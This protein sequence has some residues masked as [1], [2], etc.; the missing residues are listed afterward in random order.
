[1]FGRQ[2]A[3]SINHY[4]KLGLWVTTFRPRNDILGRG[5]NFVQDVPYRKLQGSWLLPSRWS[6][7][8]QLVTSPLTP[9]QTPPAGHDCRSPVSRR[10]E[11]LIHTTDLSA[12]LENPM[13]WWPPD[14]RHSAI[15]RAS[16]T[17]FRGS[18]F[19]WEK[20]NRS[21][22]KLWANASISVLDT[23]MYREDRSRSKIRRSMGV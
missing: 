3:T 12:I 5:P 2:L 18:M 13:I 9:K 19:T 23:T 4:R 14:I 21:R 22:G 1:M 11:T 6:I 7:T 16:D 15:S 8:R 20:K 10:L 17:S